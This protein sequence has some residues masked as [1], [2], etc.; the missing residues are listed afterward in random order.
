MISK[1]NNDKFAR[2]VLLADLYIFT[3]LEINDQ[4]HLL[5]DHF[6]RSIYSKTNKQLLVSVF[7]ISRI[8]KISVRDI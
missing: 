5:F 7:M 8:I 2:F 4:F 6:F 3:S 1:G